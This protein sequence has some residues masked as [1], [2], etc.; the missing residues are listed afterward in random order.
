M[1][2]SD[3]DNSKVEPVLITYNRASYV[4]ATLNAFL[5]AGLSSMRFHVLDNCSSDNTP[6]VVAEIQK[7]WPTLQY[8]RN[9]YNIGGNGNILR[10]VEI[11][12]SEYSWIVGDDDQ[13]HLENVS[14]LKSAF[15]RSQADII[16]LGWLVNESS[17]DR[18]EDLRSLALSDPLFFA[19]VSM[20]SAT[21]VRR[22]LIA[23]VLPHAYMNI[24][25]AYPQLVP[26]LLAAQNDGVRVFTLKRNLLTHTPNAAPGYYFG[27]L[28]WYSAW[29]RTSRYLADRRLRAKFIWEIA[30]YMTRGNSSPLNRLVWYSKVALNYKARGV[31][32]GQHLFTMLA[33]G[34][35][36]R[37]AVGLAAMLY[38]LVPHKLAVLLLRLYKRWRGSVDRALRYD[39]GRL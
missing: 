21:I 3:W 23:K 33:Y 28:E 34:V 32:Q 13:W 9:R 35:G 30:H 19:S 24:G 17:R 38:M 12:D 5:A 7:R 31:P 6:H 4:E 36:A 15:Q 18:D 22:S 14:D 25:D 10:A 39:R 2:G 20:I 11:S 27:D 37:L 1:I 26:I 16:R 8:H 29:F